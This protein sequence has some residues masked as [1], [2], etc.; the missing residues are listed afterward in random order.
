VEK[1][2][3]SAESLKLLQIQLGLKKFPGTIEGIDIA[4]TQG[5]YT[6]ASV[7]SFS[8]GFPDKSHYRKYKISQLKEPDDFEAM[9]IVAR[10][11]FSKTPLPDLLLIDGGVGQ[12]NAV[13]DVLEEELN[14]KDYQ[15]IGLAKGEETIVFPDD[16]GELCLPHDSPSLRV[17]V[18]VRDE[19]H[20]FA[21]AFHAQLRDER[22]EKTELENI[23][24]IG[25]VRKTRLLKHF[26]SLK[27]IAEA[28]IDEINRIVKDKDL[29]CRIKEY[30]GHHLP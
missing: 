5:L 15:M 11:R 27:K 7:V 28:E 19:A 3:L 14:I 24:G 20:R 4:H 9:R 29:A 18:F 30:L 25:K 13:K 1:K 8:N 17:L 6:V 22:M 21:N 26:K 23:P 12:V 10:R 16:R 2:R